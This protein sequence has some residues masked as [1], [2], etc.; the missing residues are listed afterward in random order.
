MVTKKQE[1]ANRRNAQKSTGP[2]TAEGKA[3]VRTNAFKHGLLSEEF[4][5]KGEDPE[6]FSYLHR[7]LEAELDPVGFQEAEIVERMAVQMWRLRRLYR[8]EA[9]I[10]AYKQAVVEHDQA[11]KERLNIEYGDYSDPEDEE[12]DAEPQAEDDIAYA[13]ILRRE[14]AA[15]KRLAEV[16][17]SIGV[18]YMRDAQ[19][20]NAI[21]KLSRYETAMEREL[22]RSR[23]EL[24]R[25]QRARKENL[26]RQPVTI[27]NL[28]E[29]GC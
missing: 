10:F 28:D 20:A 21:M 24:E 7:E 16:S 18:A 1:E 22:S 13:E 17:T 12:D 9:G 27:D 11:Q 3:V 4:I 29:A 25:L 26:E 19:G 8:V 5:I 2:K 6:K 23:A 15:E 14:K